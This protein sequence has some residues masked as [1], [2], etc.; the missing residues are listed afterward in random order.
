MSVSLED[1]KAMIEGAFERLS[2][3]VKD[4][5]ENHKVLPSSIS[6]PYH[7]DGKWIRLNLTMS[8]VQDVDPEEI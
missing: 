5:L 1:Q 8:A 4:M 7:K 2:E 6:I 3:E